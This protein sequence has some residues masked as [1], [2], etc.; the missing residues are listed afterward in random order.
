MRLN[1]QWSNIDVAFPLGEWVCV[2]IVKND[3]GTKMYHNASL[4]AE[5]STTMLPGDNLTYIGTQYNGYNEYWNGSIDE[6]RIWD[7]ELTQDQIS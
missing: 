7:V 1:H 6:I 4:V 5:N 2:T 3:N